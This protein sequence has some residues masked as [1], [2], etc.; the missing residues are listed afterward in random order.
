MKKPLYLLL[1]L[2]SVSVGALTAHAQ[3]YDGLMATDDNSANS[4]ASDNADDGGYS[5]VLAPDENNKARRGDA[6]EPLGYSGIIPGRA[7]PQ[8]AENDDAADTAATGNV[9]KRSGSPDFTG[10]MSTRDTTPKMS[11]TYGSFSGSQPRSSRDIKSIATI[12]AFDKNADNVPDEMANKFRL[13]AEDVKILE[14]PRGRVKGMLPI[15]HTFDRGIEGMLTDINDAKDPAVRSKRIK[16]TYDALSV[17]RDGL[18]SR[19][20]ISVSVYKAMGLPDTYIKEEREG[21]QKS[22]AKVEMALEELE[23]FRR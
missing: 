3:G 12:Y 16:E 21:A 13:P 8:P 20:S 1:F 4:D 9:G 7:A 6:Q 2:L 10:K 19:A 11:P 14:S 18:K 5:G 17:M 22:L 23:K 15:E